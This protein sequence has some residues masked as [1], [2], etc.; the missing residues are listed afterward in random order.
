MTR[1]RH[2]R[3][4]EDG[5]K[6]LKPGKEYGIIA[7]LCCLAPFFITFFNVLF[8]AHVVNAPWYASMGLINI[9][10]FMAALVF[11]IMGRKTEGR[12]YA[13]VALAFVL[14]FGLVSLVGGIIFF[15]LFGVLKL[16]T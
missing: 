5:E 6:P 1:D 12:P 15:I 16:P 4:D 13:N 11:G 9:L 10:S 7:L 3:N 2:Q 8:A 14:S